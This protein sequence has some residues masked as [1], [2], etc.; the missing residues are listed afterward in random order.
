MSFHR[1]CH[2]LETLDAALQEVENIPA[3]LPNCLQLK[4]VVTKA[5]RW[6][7]EA[8]ALQVRNTEAECY[9]S[10]SLGLIWLNFGYK[11][12]VYVCVAAWGPYSCAGQPL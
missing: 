12:C 2:S 11:S 1:P 10:F 4:D 8:E 7:H 5:K 9:D 3:Y 6:L